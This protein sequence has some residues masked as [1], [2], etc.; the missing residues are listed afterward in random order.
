MFDN[1]KKMNIEVILYWAHEAREEIEQ[2]ELVRSRKRL[3]KEKKKKL[4][5]NRQR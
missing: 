1:S 5:I 2:N 4:K 3:Q